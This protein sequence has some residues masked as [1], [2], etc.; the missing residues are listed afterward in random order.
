MEWSIGRLE[1][2]SRMRARAITELA[3]GVVACLLLITA[4]SSRATPQLL[5]LTYKEP[6]PEVRAFDMEDARLN[7]AYK[8]LA[9]SLGGVKREALRDEER[10][11]IRDR[12]KTCMKGKNY[13]MRIRTANRADELERRMGGVAAMGGDWGYRTDC[14]FGGH[15]IEWSIQKL[16]SGTIVG[17]WSD[18][19]R[20][21]GSR[22]NFKG[23]WRDGR[24]YVR[25][26][27]DEDWPDGGTICPEY[28]AIDGYLVTRGNYL[29][30]FRTVGLPEEGKFREYVTLSRKPR[31]GDVPKD[32]YCGEEDY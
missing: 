12:D 9:A 3:K 27:E 20:L 17:K 30:W 10:R 6:T 19:S 31:Y 29:V 2:P 1:S 8:A 4:V 14:N 18:G 5:S 7:A 16:G 26:C 22:G 32:N 24:L 28:G 21:Q 11:W 25:F 23:E 13:C 15:Y